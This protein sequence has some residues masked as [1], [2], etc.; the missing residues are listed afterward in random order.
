MTHLPPLRFDQI[1]RLSEVERQAVLRAVARTRALRA[2]EDL[3]LQGDGGGDCHVIVDGVLCRYKL[4]QDGKRQIIGFQIAGDLCDLTGL[5][6]GRM[7]H[8]VGALTPAQVAVIPHAALAEVMDRHPR[9][10]RALWQETHVDASITREWV[11]NVGRRTAY[12]RIA[13]LLCE[14]NLRLKAAGRALDGGSF[15]WLVTQADAADAMGLS[16]VHVNRMLQQLRGEGLIAT[17]GGE[18]A[19]LDWPGLQRAGDFCPDYL[20]LDDGE[21]RPG[22][23]PGPAGGGAEPPTP[24]GTRGSAVVDGSPRTVP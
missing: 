23:G 17:R 21:A 1:A 4:L 22:R 9:V 10:A 2:G 24:P 15:A 12:Q 20:F 19:I 18:V 3:V 8:S 13:H 11:A 16:N 6:M 7:D 14:M 5:M